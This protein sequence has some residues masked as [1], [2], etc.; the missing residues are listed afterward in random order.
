MI[1]TPMKRHLIHIIVAVAIVGSFFAQLAVHVP[2]RDSATDDG[3]REDSLALVAFFH[4]T[5]GTQWRVPWDIHQPLRHWHGVTIDT[6]E[7]R[8]V[9]LSLN[10]NHLRGKLP[11]ALWKLTALKVLRLA[12]NQ[13]S[14]PLPDSIAQLHHLEYLVL[15]DNQLSG[16]LPHTLGQLS[17]LKVLSLNKNKLQGPI[18]ASLGMLTRLEMLLLNDNQLDDT[19]PPSIAQLPKL[20]IL[21]LSHNQLQGPLPTQWNSAAS[22]RQV[23][24][25]A[26]RFSGPIPATLANL[27]KLTHLHLDHN[28]FSGSFPPIATTQ[29]LS[30]H[31]QNNHLIDLPDLSHLQ[32]IREDAPNGLDLRSNY[33]TFEDLLPLWAV[34]DSGHLLLFPQDSYPIPDTITAIA[35]TYFE[36]RLPFGDSIPSNF[37]TW[38]KYGKK[39]ELTRTNAL[40][41][42]NPNLTDAGPYHCV[43]KND[44]VIGEAIATESFYLRVLPSDDCRVDDI[45]EACYLVDP[46]CG[47]DAIAGQCYHL[48]D[49]R[50]P[51][52]YTIC[53]KSYRFGDVHWFGFVAGDSTL[54]LRCSPYSHSGITRG[55]LVAALYANCALT[56]IVRCD[57]FCLNSTTDLV[58]DGLRPGQSYFLLIGSCA[59]SPYYRLEVLEGGHPPKITPPAQILGPDTVCSALAEQTYSLPQPITG[60]QHYLW[61]LDRDS[62]IRTTAPTVDIRWPHTGLHQLCVEAVG[63]CDTT[64]RLC[65][66][67]IV[68][69]SPTLWRYQQ[70]GNRSYI[71]QFRIIGGQPP[72]TIDGITGHLDPATHTFASD[73]LRCGIPYH[74]TVIDARGCTTSRTAYQPCACTTDAGALA[75][76]SLAVCYGNYFRIQHQTPPSLDH[77]DI[78]WFILYEIDTAF[79]PAVILWS[80]DG[81]FTYQP[82]QIDPDK[83]Y[84]VRYVAANR[85]PTGVIDWQDPCLDTTPPVIVRFFRKPYSLTYADTAVCFGPF[86]L[87]LQAH[88][89][90]TAISWHVIDDSSRLRIDRLR[91][92]TVH[93]YPYQPGH[94]RLVVSANAESCSARDT[95]TITVRP[96]VEVHIM[97]PKKLCGASTFLSVDSTYSSIRWNTGD[98]TATI[99]VRNAGFYSV[100]V[101]DASGCS[102]TDIVEIKR[103]TAV[104]P[105]ITAPSRACEGDTAVLEVHPSYASY[106]WSNGKTTP[107]IT[108]DH[109]GQWCLTVTDQEGC[110]GSAC[111]T[112]TFHPHS[113]LDVYDTICHGDFSVAGRDTFYHQG[114]YEIVLPQANTHGCDSIV[115]L[116]LKVLPPIELL[117]TLLIHDDG[118]HQ[119]A[120]S[121]AVTGGYPPYTYRWNTGDTIA[122]IRQLA[123]GSYSVTVTDSK[124]CSA[125]FAFTIR[126]TVS[127]QNPKPKH[128]W[129]VHVQLPMPRHLILTHQSPTP[130]TLQWFLLNSQGNTIHRG[131]LHSLPHSQEEHFSLHHLPSGHYFI[132]IFD[133][134]GHHQQQLL[135]LP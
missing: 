90:D 25:S 106:R 108:V 54:R 74:I 60:A 56:E 71:V 120:I 1:A 21:N 12:N 78:G 32:A 20:R 85:L 124:G 57:T 52:A 105:Q 62:T 110:T 66:D 39:Y 97:G 34:R 22:L 55:Y 11:P 80:D 86:T 75:T 126:N 36:Y 72:F 92:T 24:L 9:G 15:Y 26:N 44:S 16:P 65:K 83:N 96:P 29:L 13:L 132:V 121:I 7:Q 23:F 100:T 33:L 40:I 135:H 42:T 125:T 131:T 84:T 99:E 50:R 6:V 47:A 88:I 87:D 101:T 102:G 19:I 8:V 30:L 116:H 81:H 128:R 98:T 111:H 27:P 127:T 37:Y 76:H 2:P 79:P 43:V 129:N 58:Y 115:V 64:T 117:D 134:Y 48:V 41:L 38:Y 69:E 107:T 14:G 49:G 3:L 104:Q 45:P 28:N 51:T 130:Q 63:L 82:H 53:G 31:L 89:A 61:T 73:S 103:G 35:G 77:D 91:G 118:T 67:I 114:K 10:G 122:F 113:Q 94:Y 133:R 17:Q 68:Y 46:Q 112:I 4:A 119:G 18:P 93:V 95:I 5:G 70:I 123:A 109:S 59:G